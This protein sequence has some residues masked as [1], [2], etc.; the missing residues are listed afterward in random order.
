MS[1][2]KIKYIVIHCTATRPDAKVDSFKKYWK[3]TLGWKNVG[4]HVLIDQNGI[5]HYLADFNTI[6]NGVK[7]FNHESIH[8][9]YIGGIDANGKAKDTRTPQQKA[10]L[11][12]CIRE[13][14]EWAGGK[15][16]IQ[17][18]R[19]FPNVKKDCPSFDCSE[20]SWITA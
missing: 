18:H 6:T 7:G 12:S 5:P 9:S 8:I 19:D 13:A 11:L 17:G 10:T 16:I 3:E 1:A 14:L 2:R 4:Y 15:L 20:Y